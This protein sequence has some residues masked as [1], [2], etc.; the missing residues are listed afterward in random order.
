M[1]LLPLDM[2]PGINGVPVDEHGV[3]HDFKQLLNSLDKDQPPSYSVDL[4][5]KGAEQ[6]ITTTHRANHKE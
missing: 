5:V 1:T 2:A 3:P 6:G 4:N